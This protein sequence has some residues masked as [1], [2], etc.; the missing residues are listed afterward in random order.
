MLNNRT[1]VGVM[2]LR[3]LNENGQKLNV[4]NISLQ[5]SPHVHAIL[6][7]TIITI[8][9]TPTDGQGFP[10]FSGTSE[11]E[12]FSSWSKGKYSRRSKVRITIHPAK[13]IVQHIE[14]EQDWQQMAPYTY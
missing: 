9:N 14:N 13:T 6:L 1:A 7:D 5:S 11:N 10:M 2:A 8:D 4:V 12:Y 3:S